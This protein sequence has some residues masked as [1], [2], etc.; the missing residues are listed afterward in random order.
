MKDSKGSGVDRRKQ[1]RYQTD[2]PAEVVL[3]PHGHSQRGIILNVSY[4]GV[5]VEIP[6]GAEVGAQIEILTGNTSIYGEVRNCKPV[7]NSFHVG[8]QI[9]DVFFVKPPSADEHVDH[10]HLALYA[11]GRGLTILAV[12][13]IQRHLAG[14]PKCNGDLEEIAQVLRLTQS[15]PPKSDH[16]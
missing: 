5:Q 3:P 12:I 11:S 16:Q 1:I 15:S 13:M 14:C 2:D 7:G 10:D 8:V 4:S 9:Q 6:I